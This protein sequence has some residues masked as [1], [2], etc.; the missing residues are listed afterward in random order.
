MAVVN[1]GS[2]KGWSWDDPVES[3]PQWVTL[4]TCALNGHQWVTRRT[5]LYIGP[6]CER[7]RNRPAETD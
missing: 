2:P 5:L 4:M 6:E 1:Q 7:C 3:D